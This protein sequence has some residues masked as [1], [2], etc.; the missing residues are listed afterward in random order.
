MTDALNNLE[1]LVEAM[2]AQEPLPEPSRIRELIDSLR[3]TALSAVRDE[4]AEHLA[5]VLPL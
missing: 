3:G 4:E 1:L 2:L 5:R